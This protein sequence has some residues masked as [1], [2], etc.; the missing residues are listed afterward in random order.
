MLGLGVRQVQRLCAAVRHDGADGLVSRKRGRPSS[1]RFPERLTRTIVTLITEHYAGLWSHACQREAG[2]TPRDQRLERRTVR[3]AWMIQAGLWKTRAQRKPKIQQAT[4]PT[5][6]CF[7]ELIQVDAAQNTAGLEDRASMCVLLV[8]VDDATGQL[9]GMRFCEYR[10]DVRVHGGHEALPARVR[11][12]GGVLQ[13]QALQVFRVNKVVVRMRT[14]K[15]HDAVWPGFT[16]PQHR[17]H[18]Q[19]TRRPPRVGVERANEDAPDRLPVK[20]LRL[21]GVA[22]IDAA[23][24]R[25]WNRSDR[26]FNA[27]VRASCRPRITTRIAS[28]SRLSAFASTTCSPA[29]K[30]RA[31]CRPRS[32]CSTTR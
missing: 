4:T 3:Q 18:L 16:R 17:G 19:P 23:A 21:A 28:C 7:G 6:P 14:A 22:S 31:P 26:D 27:R 10:V 20:E 11:Q 32:R 30:S 5:W 2:R 1:H 25:S 29:G 8:F 15:E 9:V 12:A 13:R 24:T